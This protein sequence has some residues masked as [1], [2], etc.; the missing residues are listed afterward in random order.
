MIN[1]EALI[2]I[3]RQYGESRE[4]FARRFPCAVNSIIGWEK[5]HHTPSEIFL[6]KYRELYHGLQGRKGEKTREIKVRGE[7]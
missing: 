5:G 2:W 6:N 3:R 1:K 7:E 4:K